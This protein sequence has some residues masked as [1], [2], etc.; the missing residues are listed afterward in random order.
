M[1]SYPFLKSY[2]EL[3]SELDR[4]GLDVPLSDDLSCLGQPLTFGNT[5]ACK[6]TLTLPNRFVAQPMEG[7]DSGPDGEP[8]ELGIRRYERFAAGGAGLIWF[9]ATAVIREARCNSQ[10]FWI[11]TKSVNAFAALE[12]R[13][14]S[15]ARKA[16]GHE[17]VT[18]IQLTHSGRYSK[19]IRGV[20][21]PIIA[22]H[23]SVLDAAH[24]LPPD[25][26]L[27][28][29]DELDRL[30]DDYVTAAKLAAKCGFDGVD[31]KSCHGY[32][33]NELLG[34][35][36]REGKYGGSFENRTRFFRETVARIRDEV[37]SVF[38]TSRF[39]VYD[40]VKYP[41]GFGADEND[42]KKWDLTE[43]KRLVAALR[44]LGM[45]LM[46]ITIGNPYFNPHYNRPYAKA[47]R[48]AV[49]Y[50]ENPLIGIA[51]FLNIVREIQQSQP[52]VPMIGAGTAWLRH[53]V[54][55]VAAGVVQN[56]WMTLFG[57]GRGAFAYP[58]S[59]QDILATGEMDTKKVCFACSGCTELM[60]HEQPTG[61]VLRDRDYYRLDT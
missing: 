20:R 23:N 43:S 57:Q 10:Q 7:F 37:P 18:I 47:I 32:L 15:F 33:L 6:K 17:I 40:A 28:T 42:Y 58:D 3:R 14:R 61:C 24:H 1:P 53:L 59:P 46:N 35:R 19:P 49:A 48:G 8:A 54:P 44:E 50:D 22:Q 29:D 5:F 30:Q 34:A 2:D 31:V 26:P 27:I 25:H 38:V 21:Q 56:G 55:K 45:P 16:H 39:N 12:E 41:W 11:N 51:R 9:E 36:T 60:R 52:D 4:L 13:T